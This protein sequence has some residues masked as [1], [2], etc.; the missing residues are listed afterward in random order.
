MVEP[1]LSLTVLLEE[2]CLKSVFRLGE[3]VSMDRR[4]ECFVDTFGEAGGL[5]RMIVGEGGNI[6]VAVPISEGSFVRTVR[7]SNNTVGL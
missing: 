7:L 3:T 1:I 5:S 6:V 2:G 4:C